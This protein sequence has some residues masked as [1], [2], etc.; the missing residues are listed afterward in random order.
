M[1]IFV[2]MCVKV[3]NGTQKCSE[4]YAALYKKS[5]RSR[6]V[7]LRL[8][9][10]QMFKHKVLSGTIILIRS[11]IWDHYWHILTVVPPDSR[12]VNWPIT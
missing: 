11:F 2:L 4:L 7:F 3:I 1:Y 6:G 8:D 5:L 9:F 12:P 10:T